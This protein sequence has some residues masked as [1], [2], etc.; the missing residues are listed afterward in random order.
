MDRVAVASPPASYMTE[1][2]KDKGRRRGGGRR[3]LPAPP[4][5]VHGL[6]SCTDKSLAKGL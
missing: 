2:T 4:A 3:A 6:P 5:E 1:E